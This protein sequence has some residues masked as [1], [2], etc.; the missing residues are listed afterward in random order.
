[1]STQDANTTSI[2]NAHITKLFWSSDA[3]WIIKRGSNTIATLC[4]T[5]EW[6]DEDSVKLEAAI[7]TTANIS[8]NTVTANATL[9]IE[10]KKGATWTVEN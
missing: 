3:N 8:M 7:D 6:D 1:M 2:T 9:V 10:L 4:G 5:G